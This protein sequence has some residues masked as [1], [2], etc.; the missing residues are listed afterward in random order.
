MSTI[1]RAEGI[2]R[3]FGGHLALS[4][5]RFALEEGTV[6]GVLGP[7]GAG[8]TTLFNVL[9]GF[10]PAT[11]GTVVFDGQVV[12]GMRS[13]RIVNLGLARTFQL[14]RPFIGMTALENIEVGCLGPRARARARQAPAV[15][16]AALAER[17]GL[18]AKSGI[19]VANLSY[20]DLRRLDIARALASHPRLL[21]L[22]E[23]LA[24]L[25]PS[26]T[27]PLL[28]LLRQLNAEEGLAILIIEHKLSEF[29]RL[30][31]RV[32]AL[33]YGKVIA[34]GTPAEIVRDARVIESYLGGAEEMEAEDA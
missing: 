7:N 23:P 11:A 26:E 18:A 1:L 34:D 32:V 5:V 12:T 13:D 28:T 25:G 21:L 29:M 19:T 9:S 15:Q 22:D 4:D 30:V 8:K 33:D 24:G 6:T 27:E 10:I 2:T 14:P 16:A 31:D 20:G 3:R 17:V